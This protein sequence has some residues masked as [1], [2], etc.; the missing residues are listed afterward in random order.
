MREAGVAARAWRDGAGVPGGGVRLAV[1]T[2]RTAVLP[3]RVHP[4]L[5]SR[6]ERP[7]SYSS[8]CREHRRPPKF[9]CLTR[10]G[11]SAQGLLGGT[12]AWVTC[13]S[14][15]TGTHAVTFSVADEAK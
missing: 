14:Q 3:P 6:A 13:A 7:G 10:T 9:G 12:R 4:Q 2:H 11:P 15:P 5:H 8:L 1:Q